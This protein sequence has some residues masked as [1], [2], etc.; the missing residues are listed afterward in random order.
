MSDGD[1]DDKKD[2]TKAV[3]AG[4][5]PKDNHGVVN[6]P[7]YHAS[8]ILQPTLKALRA[9]RRIRAGDGVT[10]GVHGTPGTYALEEAIATL[11]AGGPSEARTRLCQSGLTAVAAPLLSFLS[12]GDHLLVTDSCYGPTR[13]FCDGALKRFGVETTYYDPT[14][15]GEIRSLFQPNTRVV[16]CESPGSWTFE[17]QD[18]P[19]I[20][21]EANRAGIWTFLDNTWASPLYFKPFQHG[22]DVSIQAA[23]KYISGH[24]DLVLGAVTASRAAYPRLQ[25]G[26]QEMGFCAGP[27]DVYLA[28]RGLRTIA[29]RLKTHWE[30]GLKV[31]DWLQSQ[32]E[33][34]EVMHP[35]VPGDQGYSL[36]R[37][38][39]LGAS[40][41]FGFVLH[42]S[43]S[44]EALL[45]ALLDDLE[46]FGMGFS[47]GGFESLL[48][49]VDP[50]KIRT[51]TRWPRPGRPEGQ[52]M[53]IH[54]GLEDVSDLIADLEAGFDR[55]RHAR[56][57]GEETPTES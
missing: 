54:V 13:V 44:S 49:P 40:G 1:A 42:P 32:P 25:R 9:S 7:V 14:I 29:P 46:L 12:A 33:V 16:F 4:R 51:A 11:E 28:M 22:V 26:W 56:D 43:S 39:F 5:R 21:E 55:L 47:W 57:H 18:V 19:A 6:P 24:S 15:G 8:T 20:A 45:A 23:T 38:D 17:V 2:A 34:V 27:D 37:R 52:V 48:L 35:A 30:S 41:L 53:R 10:Y 31:A 36:W 50:P 3:I